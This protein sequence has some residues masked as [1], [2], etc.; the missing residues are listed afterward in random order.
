MSNNGNDSGATGGT[1]VEL[2]GET[3]MPLKTAMGEMPMPLV[4]RVLPRYRTLSNI[5]PHDPLS[6]PFFAHA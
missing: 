5:C 3:P 1:P 2:M 6:H 4:F